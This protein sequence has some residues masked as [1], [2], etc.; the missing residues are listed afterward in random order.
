MEI[1][2]LLRN[3]NHVK[4]RYKGY[5]SPIDIEQMVEDCI[6][7]IKK[8]LKTIELYKDQSNIT[9]EEVAWLENALIYIRNNPGDRIISDG[10]PNKYIIYNEGKGFCY[11]DGSFLGVDIDEMCKTHSKWVKENKIYLVKRKVG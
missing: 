8:L 4:I 11:E 6:D 10:F 9:I 1:D 7:N 5:K 3:L 2:D